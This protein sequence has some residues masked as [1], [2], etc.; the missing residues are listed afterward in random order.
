MCHADAGSPGKDT[1]GVRPEVGTRK[2]GGM[3]QEEGMV[4][5][6]PERGEGGTL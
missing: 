3:F 6:K 1:W 4:C 2:M 5:A